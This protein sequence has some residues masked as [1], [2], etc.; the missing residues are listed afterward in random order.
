MQ[1][2]FSYVEDYFIFS[3]CHFENTLAFLLSFNPYNVEN[4]CIWQM[5]VSMLRV[6]MLNLF[7]LNW[8][9]YNS[10]YVYI[11]YK[12]IFNILKRKLVNNS[13]KTS[14][15]MSDGTTV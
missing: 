7:W 4:Y 1:I 5:G 15:L 9:I 13:I 3:F 2:T 14:R 6:K 12:Y 8:Y 11:I 10:K